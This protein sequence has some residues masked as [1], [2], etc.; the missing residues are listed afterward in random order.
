MSMTF[1]LFMRI[2]DQWLLSVKFEVEGVKLVQMRNPKGSFEWTGPWKDGGEEWKKNKGI[3][4]A[5]KVKKTNRKGFWNEWDDGAFWMATS[6]V[7]I[8]FFFPGPIAKESAQ[9]SRYF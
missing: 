8:M 2:F 4:Q 3:S 1:H 9:K 5:L 7:Q 6:F